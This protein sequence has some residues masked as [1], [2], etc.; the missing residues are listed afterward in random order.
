MQ[1]TSCPVIMKSASILANFHK[2]NA[3][4]AAVVAEMPY[5]L[6]LR[7]EDNQ[8][9]IP[10]TDFSVRGMK[11]CSQTVCQTYFCTIC[12]SH[13]LAASG[14]TERN[15]GTFHAFEDS[16]ARSKL[17]L[18]LQELLSEYLLLEDYYMSQN[19]K[20]AVSS[21]VQ[22]EKTSGGMSDMV[23]SVTQAFIFSPQNG[24]FYR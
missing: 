14:D 17:S 13:D 8:N 18:S 3:R 21:Y 24:A 5:N 9:S 4:H 15:K 7:D 6:L 11:L 20:K 12:F 10:Y 23:H 19:V 22:T 1:S 2:Q 16:L